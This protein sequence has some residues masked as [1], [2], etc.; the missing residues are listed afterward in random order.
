MYIQRLVFKCL[1]LVL[2]LGFCFCDNGDSVTVHHRC[3]NVCAPDSCGSST[4]VTETCTQYCDPC[5]SKCDAYYMLRPIQYGADNY[6]IIQI[7]DSSDPNC[8]TL[9]PTIQ[10]YCDSCAT[11]SI[12]DSSELCPKFYLD[13]C[14]NASN[15]WIYLL[16]GIGV[17]F[18][19]AVVIF[20]GALFYIKKIKGK[21]H[22][23]FIEDDSTGY[24]TS[25][26]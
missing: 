15:W 20:A 13:N 5:T 2:L 9:V 18:V 3:G 10:V 25:G 22:D 16:I 14:S 19:I 17:V 11:T 21:K 4:M 26:H 23:N 24:G 8:A 12:S 7:H 6:Y 1:L